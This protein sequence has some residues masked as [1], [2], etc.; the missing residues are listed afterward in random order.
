M[1]RT[2][3]N[4]YLEAQANTATPQKLRLMLIDGGLRFARQTLDHWENGC[5]SE[6]RE[7]C[8]RCRDVLLELLSS[9]KTE[10]SDIANQMAD[11][12]LFLVRTIT[13]AEVDGDPLWVDKVIKVLEVERG[14]WQELC[15]KYPN[16]VVPPEAREVKVTG[17]EVTLPKDDFP[18]RRTGDRSYPASGNPYVDPGTSHKGLSLDG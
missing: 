5:D 18:H 12:Y 6:A 14:T 1:D 2:A 16:T 9:L 13:Q 11:V 15:N 8:R 17:L 3:Q 10:K 4:A 7:A